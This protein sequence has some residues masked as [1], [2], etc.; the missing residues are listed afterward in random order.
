MA[1]RRRIAL[2]LSLLLAGTLLSATTATASDATTKIAPQTVRVQLKSAPTRLDAAGRAHVVM[3]TKCS[4]DLFLFE[5]D[6]SVVQGDNIGQVT[7]LRGTDELPVC[8]GLRHRF[9]VP[10]APDQGTFHRGV[11]GIGV[12]VGAFDSANDA[13]LEATDEVRVRL[14]RGC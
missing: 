13:D 5:I 3:W 9:V 6:V 1:Q 11:A 8:D 7:L 4:P 2:T 14:T 12:F 10:V